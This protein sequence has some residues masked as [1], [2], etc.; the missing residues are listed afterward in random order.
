MTDEYFSIYEL[1][2]ED[3]LSYASVIDSKIENEEFFRDDFIKGHK[4]MVEVCR[5]DDYYEVTRLY[6]NAATKCQGMIDTLIGH[7]NAI[8]NLFQ[9]LSDPD[10]GEL[11]TKR[12][13]EDKQWDKIAKEMA[14]TRPGIM[15][16]KKSAINALEAKLD[17]M[18]RGNDNG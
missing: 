1:P 6:K 14:Y 9:S 17:E 10:Y 15:S 18:R 5:L 2:V 13:L 12:Y 8:L 3:F 7:K 11:L 16:K 4:F